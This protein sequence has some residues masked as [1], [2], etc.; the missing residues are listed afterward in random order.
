MW[1]TSR[2]TALELL[3]R[4]IIYA[5]RT[6]RKSAGFSVAAILTLSLGIGAN[7]A[8]FSV[9]DAVLLRPL[10]YPHPERLVRVWQTEP[11]MSSIRIGTAPPEFVSYRDRTHAFSN[12]AG[13]QNISYDVTELGDP[14]HVPA[15]SASATLFAVLGV[16][17]LMGRTFTAAE[18]TPGAGRVALLNYAFWQKRFGGDRGVLG[19]TIRLNEMPYEI[20]GVMP[21]GFAFP[22]TD[23]SPGEPPALW[24]PISFTKDQLQDWASSFDTSIVARLR[25]EI[26]LAEA[27][28]DVARTSLAFQNEH[29]DIYSGN[30]IL[31]TVVEPW[32]GNFGERVPSTLWMLGGAAAFV[33]LIACANV[34]NLLLARAGTRQREIAIRRALGAS[35]SRLV[36]QV[37]AESAVL[38]I[39]GGL[40][41]CALAAALIRLVDTLWAGA[42][43]LRAVTIDS[44]VLVFTLA[45]S[46]VTCLLC[47]VAPAWGARAIPTRSH[48]QRRVARVLIVAEVAASL[49]LLIGSGLLFRSFAHV[50][51]APLGFN[52]QATLIVRTALNRRRYPVPER[53]HEIERAIVSRLTALPGVDSVA[54]TTHVPLADQRQIGFIAEGAP[55]NDFH[56]ADN[57]LVS[58]D[59]FRV[60]GIPLLRGRS[61]STAD[62]TQ[63]P[64][65]AVINETMAKQTW[66]GEDALGKHFK[67]AGRPL[68]VV[69]IASDIHITALDR[70]VGATIYCS[71]YQM[72][73][74]ASTSGVFVLRMRNT[75]DPMTLSSAAQNAIWAVDHGVPIIG[76][77]TLERVV[78]GSLAVRRASLVLAGGFAALAVILALIGLYGV[79]SYAI[80]Q[81]TREMGLRV[82]LGAQPGSIVRLV[83]AD[84]AILTTWGVAAGVAGAAIC[85]RFLSSLLFG[86]RPLDPLV[87]LVGIVLLTAVS[88]L[89]AYLPARRAS[90]VDPL[91]ALREE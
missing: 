75:A 67:W 10:P 62:T 68:T 3:A 77:T 26:S 20:V 56:W 9:M 5:L 17:P 76:F 81:R 89:A 78:A 87:Y 35:P 55:P 37:F 64:W 54:V 59:Y 48:P 11:K 72:E 88:L 46:I 24:T 23:A 52:P 32:K 21:R 84:G 58:E 80:T 42:V 44:R 57:A 91:T 61:F 39:A 45:L 66:P 7:T 31:D 63:T 40:A 65:V 50:L 14:E 16:S 90:R 41:G 47:G 69:G 71:V 49:V 1:S 34:A 27:A 86:V 19:R 2:W 28:A 13:Y 53:R 30:I 8:I 4:D 6:I 70:P 74:G 85:A 60:M 73:S 18:E 29:R 22:A 82:A 79:L 83:L 25:D 33:L 38:A 51:E 12:L 43:N 36:R 15:V